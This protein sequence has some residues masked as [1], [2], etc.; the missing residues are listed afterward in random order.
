M[1]DP[2]KRLINAPSMDDY[3]PYIDGWKPGNTGILLTKLD[4]ALRLAQ[5][6]S[7][8]P[9]AFGLACFLGGISGSYMASF[10]RFI[11]PNSFT[12]DM[13]VLVIIMA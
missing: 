13:S 10:M 2:E 8:W 11:A 5:T 1:S 9:L 6:N 7:L 4:Y 12:I 3:R